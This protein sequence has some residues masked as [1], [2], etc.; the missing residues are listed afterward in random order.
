MVASPDA[1]VGRHR[2]ARNMLPYS[3]TSVVFGTACRIGDDLKHS[4]NEPL[5]RPHCMTTF[6]NSRRS[7]WFSP[8]YELG[9][10]GWVPAAGC[11]R[12]DMNDSG[13]SQDTGSSCEGSFANMLK[14]DWTAPGKPAR[15]DDVCSISAM[16][17][18]SAPTSAR[19]LEPSAR[20]TVRRCSLDERPTVA[21]QNDDRSTP[22]HWLLSDTTMLKYDAACCLNCRMTISEGVRGCWLSTGTPPRLSRN[23]GVCCG[24]MDMV[25]T[26][27]KGGAAAAAALRASLRRDFSCAR[28]RECIRSSTSRSLAFAASK[29]ARHSFVFVIASCATAGST[30]VSWATSCSRMAA[31]RRRSVNS[32]TATSSCAS[33]TGDKCSSA[34]R[35]SLPFESVSVSDS[36][37]SVSN[38]K[39]ESSESTM[40]PLSR[41]WLTRSMS[42]SR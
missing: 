29:A 26:E 19:C 33:R 22:L 18:T 28:R 11:G 16:P 1:C 3:V 40:P 13:I 35:F 17:V 15:A 36:S 34:T 12:H 27:C 7:T 14:I 31:T 2:H 21:A 25:L 20:A 42:P 4:V 41:R 38:S 32:D 30:L 5:P 39:S 37:S 8:K 24:S 10:D 23:S 9:Y 6:R